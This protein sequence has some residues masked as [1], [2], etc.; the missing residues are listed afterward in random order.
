MSCMCV[1]IKYHCQGPVTVPDKTKSHA[2]NIEESGVGKSKWS[3][4]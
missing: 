1:S 2:V 4:Y 3:E